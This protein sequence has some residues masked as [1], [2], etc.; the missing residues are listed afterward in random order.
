MLFPLILLSV[1]SC[2][3]KAKDSSIPSSESSSIT[4]F[5]FNSAK[6]EDESY[7][8]DGMSHTI[9]EVSGIPTGTSVE[10][11][12]S[13]TETN[14]G[15]YKITATLKKEGYKT[16]TLTAILSIIPIDFKGLTLNSSIVTY[17]GLDH[18]KDVSVTG[19]RPEETNVAL[20]V[21][22]SK[23]EIVTSAIDVGTYTYTATITNPNYNT[24][25]LTAKLQI[26]AATTNMPVFV[27]SNNTVYF[28][29][30]L[31]N[32]YL[33]SIDSNNQIS[34]IDY[35]SPKEFNKYNDTS[36]IYISGTSFLNSVKETGLSSTNVIYTASN[37]DDF[38]RYDSSTYYYSNNSKNNQG[39]YKI[40]T[41]SEEPIV[42]KVYDGKTDNLVVYG[43]YLY[44]TNSEDNNYIYKLNL[45]NNTTSLVL[46]EKT[47]EYIIN[48][49]ILYCSVNTLANDYI[50]YVNLKGINTT[51]TKIT[52]ASGEFLTI[53][54]NK[55]YYNY[56]DL[57]G[58][59]DS[60]KLGIYSIDL[61]T[62]ENIQ[63]LA[64]GGVNG[65]DVDS[66]N[67]IYYVD[68][69]DLHLYKYNI[70]S[71]TKTDLLSNFTPSI[72]VPINLGGK[73]VSYGDTIYYLN[74]YA[75]KA[76]Y[77]YNTKTKE[78]YP[79]SSDKVVDFTIISDKLYFNQV[80]MLTNNDLYMV[81]LKLGSEAEKITT[82]DVRNLVTDGTYIYATHY[83]FAGVAAGIARM[84]LDGSDYV[85][86][87]DVNGAKNL[88]IKDNKL[89]FIACGTG[90]NGKV[91]YINLSDISS[92]SQKL[93]G[94]ILDSNLKDVKQFI[95]DN[96]NIYY[97]YDGIIENS[98]RRTTLDDISSYVTI[99]SAKTNPSEMIL[100]GDYIIY[101]SYPVS[102]KQNAGFYKISKNATADLGG[103]T[104]YLVVGYD[105]KYYATS[106]AL[107]S[108]GEIYF[109]NY[110]PQYLLGDAHLYKLNVES[111]TITLLD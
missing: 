48:N 13:R 9:S 58:L 40:E 54:N 69:Q 38:V 61:T 52:N 81:D 44:F 80:S 91:E 66:N 82:N 39:I 110:L 30:G 59:L 72:T 45:S 103:K 28:A 41:T 12:C 108:K 35:T 96:N 83:N 6:F 3:T 105:S 76:L 75:E 57:F 62:R 88:T 56:N 10:Y 19:T 64:I 74:M 92:T 87:S 2:G 84:N 1:A 55:L 104:D 49:D 34:R 63:V 70:T 78:S 60:S 8:Y 101:Y 97:I 5:E 99:A 93:D 65:F 53:K 85:K 98:I 27:D 24:I 51:S 77:A 67:N 111:K 94:T 43:S 21:K 7:T 68:T 100:V 22:N 90:D 71:K 25:T 17:D 42:T 89:Y 4:L 29:N 37:I 14:V 50:G 20:E 46:S 31:D 36:A 73:T 79:I 23:G 107:G 109:L 102:S 33:Y 106:L 86:F 15:T 16:K 47:H 32:K 18:Y 11:S 26:K 95:F